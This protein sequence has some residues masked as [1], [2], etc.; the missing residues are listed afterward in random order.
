[1]ATTSNTDDQEAVEFVPESD[2]LFPGV[3]DVATF[4]QQTL[5]RLMLATKAAHALPPHGDDYDFY[6]S[7]E[8][9]R[10]YCHSQSE[11]L[12][13]NINGLMHLQGSKA[14]LTGGSSAPEL[15]DKTDA[16][17]ETND[18]ILEKVGLLLD[19]ATGL[20]KPGKAALPPGSQPKAPPKLI[21]ASWNQQSSTESQ[22][23][24]S[25]HLMH[26]KNI[27]R[28]Q[29]KFK[30][31]INNSNT[32]FV[33]IITSKP[34]ALKPLNKGLLSPSKSKSE[35]KDIP[36]AVSAFIHQQ[37]VGTDESE[38]ITAHP[39]Q[40]ELDH[41][42]PDPSMLLPVDSPSYEPLDTT[43]LTLV[44]TVEQ[45]EELSRTLDSL[46]EF[47]VDLEHHSYR[48]FQGFTCL[49][50]ISTGRHDYIIDTLALRSELQI[51]NNSFTNP[52]IVKVFHGAD[53][54]VEW[55]QRD[56]GLYVVNMFDTGQASRILGKARNSLAHLLQLYCGLSPDKSYQLADWRIRPLPQEMISYSRADTH[57]LL[58][59]YHRMKNE[60]IERGNKANNL[61][62]QTLEQSRQVCLRRYKKLIFTDDS[63]LTLWKRSK[64]SFNPKQYEALKLLYAW[65]DRVGRQEDES[66][67]YV[68][69]NHMLFQVA[70]N[71]PREPH[72]VLACCNPIPPLVRQQLNEVHQLVLK[73]RMYQGRIKKPSPSPK[74][75]ASPSSPMETP[76]PIKLTPRPLN[77]L[78]SCPH[79][80]TPQQ[81]VP[82]Q[83]NMVRS[84]PVAHYSALFGEEAL[85]E[86][87][88]G[89]VRS[90]SP[91]ITAFGSSSDEETDRAQP[92]PGQQ[93]V[94]RLKSM[95]VNPFEMFLPP[96]RLVQITPALL[97]A[98]KINLLPAGS[99][100]GAPSSGSSTEVPLDTALSV[101]KL[102][103]PPKP[104]PA[105]AKTETAALQNANNNRESESDTEGEATE[106]TAGKE[107]GGT[108]RQ[109]KRKAP[110]VDDPPVM[111]YRPPAKREKKSDNR[112]A[113][114]H[115]KRVVDPGTFKPFDY[116]AVSVPP[117]NDG[118]QPSSGRGS[119]W[120]NRGSGWGNQ[121]RG[122]GDR[123]RGVAKHF[124]P[125]THASTRDRPEFKNKGR[126]KAPRGS[127]QH[128][129][130]YT[131]HDG[132]RNFRGKHHWPKR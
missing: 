68:L 38:D 82:D 101:W 108:L 41:F 33:P 63:Y 58:Y 12:L 27:S 100:S 92:T 102:K 123:G 93:K 122:R 4:S 87:H 90:A 37:R 39:Y 124:D 96:K 18:T 35:G 52:A 66:T 106:E 110:P 73:A 2:E 29:L 120:G 9:F 43:P 8:T 105:P 57:Y 59:I 11:R 42:V 85:P 71:L 70:E 67:G 94:A 104:P 45:L 20:I 19:E 129:V 65:R 1:M 15:E 113:N 128:S 56:L 36:D 112:K 103:K 21:V 17:I 46:N 74:I 119:G 16:I 14:H 49:M 25:F 22:K 3:K 88:P 86:V 48:S 114:P 109:Q 30:D 72:G 34:N 97:E 83:N 126:P 130:T 89:T 81:E 69:P 5:G 115:T 121:G 91:I 117:A 62:K 76:T 53:M 6:S 95:F 64:K 99:K 7:Y 44:D 32:P 10:Q 79:D 118:R 80:P 40:Y 61:L 60:L 26:A 54:D 13:Q 50:Q 75:F 84:V 125:F 23:G 28:P 131:K 98:D 127:G 77:S 132:G 47:A 24:R 51:L 55:L 78:L 31:K 111:T 116:S 107:T